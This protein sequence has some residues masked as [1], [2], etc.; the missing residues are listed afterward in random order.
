M[1]HVMRVV[2][3]TALLLGAASAAAAEG[4][5][6]EADTRTEAQKVEDA[7][8]EAWDTA[9]LEALRASTAAA[10][11]TPAREEPRA[12]GSSAPVP[13]NEYTEAQAMELLRTGEP[14]TVTWVLGPPL[15]VRG[16]WYFATSVP[17]ASRYG[18][19][20]YQVSLHR[21]PSRHCVADVV[22][23][24]SSY[25]GGGLVTH[26]ES[27]GLALSYPS[28][29][30]PSGS[31]LVHVRLLAVDPRTLTVSRAGFLGTYLGS[32]YASGMH[33]EGNR[34]LVETNRY[35]ATF[36]RFLTSEEPPIGVIF[37]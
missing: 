26:K 25:A 22:L 35:T 29:Q 6:E 7:L 11:A 20:Y 2:S 31:A 8:Q 37:P 28:K 27:E 17:I 21:I 5:P 16:C 24:G 18:P 34:L 30:T 12:T 19:P 4:Q 15:Q 3:L 13:A 1:K 14:E 9:A 23:L 36:P 33:F 10:P 32:T